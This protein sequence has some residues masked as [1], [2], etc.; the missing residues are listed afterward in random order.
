MIIFF[1]LLLPILYPMGLKDVAVLRLYII[2][3]PSVAVYQPLISGL[4][5]LHY[6][7]PTTN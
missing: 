6:G 4:R 5:P 2:L 1:M 3:A 7:L